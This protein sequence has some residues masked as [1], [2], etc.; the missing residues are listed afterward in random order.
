MD[1][2]FEEKRSRLEASLANGMTMIHL[3]ARR[4]GVV[5][6]SQMHDDHHL[7]LNLSYRFDPPDLTV[8]D[9]GVR[10]TLSFGGVRFRVAVPWEAI[11]AITGSNAGT[12]AWMFP[13]D[14]PPELLEDAARRWGL[15]G[16]EIEQ[17]KQE[18]G[19]TPALGPEAVAAAVEAAGEPRKAALRV[20]P[21]EPEKVPEGEKKEIRRGHLRLV[22]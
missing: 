6:P 18:A 2:R 13:E 21:A 4:A 22:K 1:Q 16:D 12:D 20:V 17:L 11:F 19:Q 10:E 14:M 7:R 5:V 8:G 15:T 9:W 3:D